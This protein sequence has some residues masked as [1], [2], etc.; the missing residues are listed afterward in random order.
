MNK[1]I[2]PFITSCLTIVFILWTIICIY[3]GYGLFDL[4]QHLYIKNHKIYY[5]N[6]V[7]KGVRH[8]ESKNRK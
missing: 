2:I 7:D 1:L 4:H 8:V 3:I 6:V 5:I